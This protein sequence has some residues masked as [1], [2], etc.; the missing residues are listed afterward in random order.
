M[1]FEK[2]LNTCRAGPAANCRH[3]PLRAD[4]SVG[5]AGPRVQPRLTSLK[6]VSQQSGLM[7]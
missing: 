2:S 7:L 4:G 3:N 5:T 1:P 6:S